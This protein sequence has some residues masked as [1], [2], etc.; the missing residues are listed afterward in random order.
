MPERAGEWRCSKQTK[1]KKEEMKRKKQVSTRG[2]S[3]GGKGVFKQ[4][5]RGFPTSLTGLQSVSCPD[6]CFSTGH[7]AGTLAL[8]RWGSV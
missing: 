7:P 8:S 3:R 6:D 1:N 4:A 2:F 5:V